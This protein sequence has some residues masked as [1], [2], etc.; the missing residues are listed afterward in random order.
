MPGQ[1]PPLRRNIL[2]NEEARIGN[3]Y[4]NGTT[5]DTIPGT[6]KPDPLL[7]SPTTGDPGTSERILDVH[8]D[9]CRGQMITLALS[10][11]LYSPGP[12]KGGGP[13]VAKIEFGSGNAR[14][15]IEVDVPYGAPTFAAQDSN[16]QEENS[17][18]ILSLPGSRII[19]DMRNDGNSFAYDASENAVGNLPISNSPQAGFIVSAFAAYGTRSSIGKVKR[20]LPLVSNTVPGIVLANNYPIP[21]LAKSVRILRNPMVPL[22]YRLINYAGLSFEVGVI[23]GFLP[24]PV[25]DLPAQTNGLLISSLAGVYTAF[26]DFELEV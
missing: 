11:T 24:S 25:I 4:G 19:V 26:A 7:P 8:G 9:S 2:D 23:P 12:N 16:A 22:Q 13:V 17:G 21:Q 3:T 15:T 6:Y 18:I 20:L 5:P 14:Q 1:Q 10:A